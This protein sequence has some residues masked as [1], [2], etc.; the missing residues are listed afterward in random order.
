M[1][2]LWDDATRPKKEPAKVGKKLVLWMENRKIR[3]MFGGF[4][5]DFAP[6]A[7]LRHCEARSSPDNQLVFWIASS[8]LLAMTRSASV[9]QSL[10]SASSHSLR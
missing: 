3:Q 2:S 6:T 9:I 5:Q 10:S 4:F 1:S 7:A 8:F